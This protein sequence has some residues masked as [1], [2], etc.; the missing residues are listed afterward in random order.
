M[1]NP[2][3]CRIAQYMSLFWDFVDK[4]DIEKH[5]MAW[6]IVLATIKFGFWTMDFARYSERPGMD[7]AA[8]IGAIW[9]PWSGVQ[10]MVVRW[11]FTARTDA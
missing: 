6:A 4:R 1:K 7:I 8:I 2:I 3:M 11:Y 9:L 5:A 10:A